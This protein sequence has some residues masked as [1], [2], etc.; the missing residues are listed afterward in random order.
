MWTFL[1]EQQ[2]LAHRL[3]LWW[4]RE[5]GSSAHAWYHLAWR[6][7]ISREC[8]GAGQPDLC[9]HREMRPSLFPSL[10]RAQ[11]VRAQGNGAIGWTW[12]PRQWFL[13][14]GPRALRVLLQKGAEVTAVRSLG[15]SALSGNSLT[16][17][18]GA[19]ESVG[20]ADASG[21]HCSCLLGNSQQHLGI[22]S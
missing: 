8:R 9:F 13:A 7:I 1:S 20:G 6:C 21:Q 18:P 12:W 14:A 2:K 17:V 4:M 10:L 19:G 16:H 3:V 15:P 22:P 5:V 11:L